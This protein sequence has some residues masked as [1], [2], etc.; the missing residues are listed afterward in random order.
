MKERTMGRISSTVLYSRHLEMSRH[1]SPGVGMCLHENMM[2]RMEQS[3]SLSHQA[4]PI[5]FFF[6]ATKA[7]ETTM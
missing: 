7:S 6:K 5:A 1:Q 2:A 4:K 3:E